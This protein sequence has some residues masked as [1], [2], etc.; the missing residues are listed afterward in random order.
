MQ[1]G[2]NTVKVAALFAGVGGI[3]LGLHRAGHRTVLFCEKEQNALAVLKRGFHDDLPA[4]A[5]LGLSHQFSSKFRLETGFTYYFN[6]WEDGSQ[7]TTRTVVMDGADLTAATSVTASY[8]RWF[9][10]I[11]DA[12][13]RGLK[14]T[15]G[16]LGWADVDDDGNVDLYLSYSDDVDWWEDPTNKLAR[17]LGNGAFH[18]ITGDDQGGTLG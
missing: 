11:T 14:L 2:G 7:T 15:T 3:E 9:S 1:E 18:D 6:G 16:G 17:G 8:R 10:D 5:A 4:E 13:V 12:P